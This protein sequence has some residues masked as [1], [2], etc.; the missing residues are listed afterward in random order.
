LDLVYYFDVIIVF[1]NNNIFIK[2][3]I[4]TIR[5]K[6]FFFQSVTH[7]QLVRNKKSVYL[8][9]PNGGS[10]SHHVRESLAVLI[11]DSTPWIAYS[12][13]G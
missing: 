7:A 5:M 10:R 3:L 12:G 2:E 1:T 6:V 13:T 9:S 11:L 4:I 8:P